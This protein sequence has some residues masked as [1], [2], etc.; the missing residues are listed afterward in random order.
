MRPVDGQFVTAAGPTQVLW[1]ALAAVWIAVAASAAVVQG[2][3]DEVRQA[4]RLSD[5]ARPEVA[6]PLNPQAQAAR[7]YEASARGFLF[8]RNGAWS[9]ALDALE[10]AR[11]AEVVVIAFS[12]S[13][14]DASVQVEL[15]A[16]HH[17]AAVAL[18]GKLEAFEAREGSGLRWRLVRSVADPDGRT[19]RCHLV[20]TGR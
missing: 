11:V 19:V 18:L 17:A 7:P 15:M 14:T 12:A 13:A 6:R 4:Q 10:H 1:L 20:A 2:Q 3:A 5:L 8:E 9:A 16:P